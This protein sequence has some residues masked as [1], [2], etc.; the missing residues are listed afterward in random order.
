M[1]GWAFLRGYVSAARPQIGIKTPGQT[2]LSFSP[3]PPL[4]FTFPFKEV[5]GLWASPASLRPWKLFE[6][7]SGLQGRAQAHR[8]PEQRTGSKLSD[9]Q[10]T[11]AQHSRRG[12][13]TKPGGTLRDISGS[14]L[15]PFGRLSPVSS[16]SSPWLAVCPSFLASSIHSSQS[17]YLPQRW[18]LPLRPT[19]WQ[20]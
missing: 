12:P 19:G 9:F 4:H 3:L 14:Q 1:R 7:L 2:A 13:G 15:T 20:H 10:G 16:P 6:R 11:Q 8:P 17:G 5:P 18:L